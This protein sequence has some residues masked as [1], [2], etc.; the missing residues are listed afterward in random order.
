MENV[1]YLAVL[2]VLLVIAGL[3]GHLT[4]EVTGTRAFA[5]IGSVALLCAFVAL[6]LTAFDQ[7]VQA[8]R[9]F[10]EGRK[11]APRISAERTPESF[12]RDPVKRRRY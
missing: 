1:R 10:R 6:L 11:D 7:I 3:L 12:N 9:E 8:V 2:T 4:G 5:G